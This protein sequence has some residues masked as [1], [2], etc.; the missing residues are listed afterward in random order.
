[1]V[2]LPAG[3]TEWNPHSGL[4]KP[5]LEDDIFVDV[6]FGDGTI[7][8]SQTVGYWAGS[9]QDSN[10]WVLPTYSRNCSKPDG[11]TIYGYRVLE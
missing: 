10:S 1:M 4:N 3:F 11:N 9:C 8:Y 6:I 5:D 7:S 2:K